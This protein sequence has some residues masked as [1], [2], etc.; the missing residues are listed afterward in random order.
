MRVPHSPPHHPTQHR[1]A[2]ALVAHVSAFLIIA[3][4][5]RQ[6]SNNS[7]KSM[8]PRSR[9]T[10][11]SQANSLSEPLLPNDDEHASQDEGGDGDI[12][13]QEEDDNDDQAAEQPSS[14][15]SS[16]SALPPPPRVSRNIPIV[17]AYTTFVFAGRSV[18]S[19]SVLSTFVFLLRQEDFRAVGFM[20][21]V[22]G[23]AQLFTS[24]PAGY[25][26]DRYRRDTM[27][28][29]A[30]VVALAAIAAILYAAYTSDYR[31]LVV[32]LAIW[33]SYWGISNTAMSAI[34]AD[35]IPT[36]QRSKYFT[37]RNMLRNLGIALGPILSLIMFAVLGD[38]WGIKDC[39]IVLA[40][41]QAVCLP[42]V[43]LLC[44]LSDKHVV[45]H[46]DDEHD[47]NYNGVS[48]LTRSELTA[49]PNRDEE[50]ELNPS[51]SL[52]P[53]GQPSES[54]QGRHNNGYIS[55]CW[56]RIVCFVRRRRIAVLIAI[57]DVVSG[58]ASGMSI[59]YFPIFFVENLHMGPVKVQILY[60]LTPMLM[61]LCM[62]LAQKLST[63]FGRCRVSVAFKWTGVVLMWTLV[64]VYRLGL[65]RWL[66]CT[67]YIL[68]TGF[69]NSTAA[70]TKSV[71]MDHV[72]PS[73]RGRWSALE[74]LNMFSW[75]GSA[76]LG[77]YLVGMIGMVPLFCTTAGIQFLAT[78]PL[79]RL[80]MEEKLE[81]HASEQTASEQGAAP[82]T[83]AQPLLANGDT[84][85]RRRG[86][87]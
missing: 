75:S 6:I 56:S 63:R 65:P 54:N 44:F 9:G 7:N 19:Q 24:F 60:A 38:K 31:A 21:A 14:S 74:S 67:I 85:Q 76:A 49:D 37:Q 26:A 55:S 50:D 16:S 18:W 4:S 52:I 64:I 81:G 72:P 34:F 33:G 2:P 22:M 87:V 28:R 23:L 27:L 68:L 5:I 10:A 46:E 79:V 53:S 58:L 3:C 30:S 25:L 86:S 57:A 12:M 83:L 84:Q 40:V 39:A 69:I 11:S 48:P 13:P 17:L 59:R 71:L 8:S 32:G 82:S 80:S 51:R 1:A 15:S 77:G 62:K 78:F 70:L 41:G 20:T 45:P 73:E 47:N 66:V 36:G 61:S 29:V 43:F 42:A 35:S